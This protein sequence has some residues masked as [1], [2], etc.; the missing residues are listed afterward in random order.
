MLVHGFCFFKLVFIGPKELT[1]RYWLKIL[2]L[3]ELLK[4]RFSKVWPYGQLIGYACFLVIFIHF[5]LCPILGCPAIAS[6]PFNYCWSSYEDQR[7]T[8]CTTWMESGVLVRIIFIWDIKE[9]LSCMLGWTSG[10]SQVLLW[11]HLVGGI[12]EEN[13]AK[14]L[15]LASIHE[16]S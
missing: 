9:L 4:L 13:T 14:K 3:Q 16:V 6:E 8:S 15:T 10:L 11:S 5:R 12:Q 7:T 2:S 1:H